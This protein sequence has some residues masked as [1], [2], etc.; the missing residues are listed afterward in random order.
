MT[1]RELVAALKALGMSQRAIGDAVGVNDS[2]IS[3]VAR[4]V[5]NKGGAYQ[6]AFEE[7]LAKR[8]AGDTSAVTKPAPRK[9]KAGKI[10][11]TRGARH[12][13]RGFTVSVGAAACANGARSLAGDIKTAKDAGLQAAFSVTFKATAAVSVEQKSGKARHKPSKAKVGRKK[14]P[15]WTEF[16]ADPA[17][18]LTSVITQHG[19][20]VTAALLEVAETRGLISGLGV[21]VSAVLAIEMRAW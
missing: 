4:G 3:Q 17:E 16:Q 9:T 6:A 13:A 1:P 15:E 10:A 7:L 19:G 21:Q 18:L 11:R 14:V 2:Y 8:S 12:Y 5:A 20:N